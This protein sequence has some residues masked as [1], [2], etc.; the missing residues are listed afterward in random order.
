MTSR[1]PSEQRLSR[2]ET[3][4]QPEHLT[5]DGFSLTAFRSSILEFEALGRDRSCQ[6]KE[7]PCQI[8]GRDSPAHLHLYR[9]ICEELLVHVGLE[10]I[11]WR[12]EEVLLL[13]RLMPSPLED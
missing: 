5:L 11:G 3:S 2:A 1:R 4:H 9:A 8:V 7:T 12:L 13:P 6:L 10:S